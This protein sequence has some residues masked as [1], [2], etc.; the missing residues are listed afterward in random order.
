MK[1]NSIGQTSIWNGQNILTLAIDKKY[2]EALM[3]IGY[4]RKNENNN[5]AINMKYIK[6]K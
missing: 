3:A 1:S 5:L 6:K 4:K 2:K